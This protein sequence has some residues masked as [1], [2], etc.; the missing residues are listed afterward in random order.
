M[1]ERKFTRQEIERNAQEAMENCMA[2]IEARDMRKAH[3][4]RG[5]AIV[6]EDMLVDMCIVLEHE[7]EHYNEM[8]NI[9]FASIKHIAE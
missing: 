1:K 3:C 2:Y 6:W 4:C 9:Y 5:Q 7:N 8:C